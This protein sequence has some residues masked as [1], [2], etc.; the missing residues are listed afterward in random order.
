[1]AIAI[2]QQHH[3]TSQ[4]I[5]LQSP[6][7]CSIAKKKQVMKVEPI[8]ELPIT[9]PTTPS[10][11]EDDN[12]ILPVAKLEPIK[13][14]SATSD[15]PVSAQQLQHHHLNADFAAQYTLGQELGSGGYGFV[16]SALQHTTGREVAVKFIFRE[17]IPA[18]KWAHDPKLG[19]IPMEIYILRHVHHRNI[20]EYIDCFQD[21][22]FFY[23]V[24]E[25]HGT[26]WSKNKL[27]Q[28]ADATSRQTAPRSSLMSRRSSCDLFECIE[29]HQKFT[30]DQAR[31]IVKQIVDCIKYLYSRGICHRDLKDENIVI[32]E[33]FEVKLIDFGSAVVFPRQRN[34]LFDRFYGTVSFASP[35]ILMGNPY[36][37]E[38]A[39]VWS[40]GILLY[41]ILYGE[42]PFNDPMHAISRPFTTPKLQSS[43]ECMHLLEWMLAK[44]PDHRAR[45]SQV[46]K[47]PWLSQE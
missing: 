22:R 2:S 17:K 1:M 8:C 25:L 27:S 14:T 7:T 47:H 44:H 34:H 5:H 36:R 21:G 6:K 40:L 33:N 43:H 26:G 45:I 37:A 42:V 20:I 24:M 32:D 13:K 3:P 30:E 10:P 18:N 23:L 41:T 16:V 31:R 11:M 9:P 4:L 15:I 39:E 38:P 35:E 29:Q 19:V 12:E 28:V 46:A